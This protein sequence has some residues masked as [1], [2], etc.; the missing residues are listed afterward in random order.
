MLHLGCKRFVETLFQSSKLQQLSYCNQTYRLQTR[1][2][3]CAIFINRIVLSFLP[4]K[5]YT[6]I[7]PKWNT[8][9]IASLA[10]INQ[11]FFQFIIK[12]FKS[13]IEFENGFRIIRYLGHLKTINFDPDYPSPIIF[14]PINLFDVRTLHMENIILSIWF[15]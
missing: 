12:Y 15:Y 1:P 4:S 6:V 2:Q 5:H 14:I 13:K 3:I 11:T 8:T 7:S 10:K 9:M